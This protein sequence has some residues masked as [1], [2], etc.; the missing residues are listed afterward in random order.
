MFDDLEALRERV[1]ARLLE[2]KPLIEE[3]E[4]LQKV[5]ERLRFAYEKPA[6]SKPSS[7]GGT[8]KP[9]RH[10]PAGTSTRSRAGGTQATG[11]ERRARV[12]TL[13]EQ[14]P[15]ITVSEISR[16]L[17]VDPPPIYRVV[18]RLR[19]DGLIDKAGKNL[20]IAS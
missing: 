3:Y 10:R 12:L 1:D 13:I 11:R 4:E 8:A 16:E 15:G 14:R 5:A 18:R 19:T 2:L 20:H 6:A 7:R 9:T 17:G